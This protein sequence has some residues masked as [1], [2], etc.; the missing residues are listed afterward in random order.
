MTERFPP[1][2]DDVARFVQE[3]GLVGK[4]SPSKFY[5]YYHKQNFM[6]QGQPMDWRAKVCKWAATETRAVQMN[7]A[8]YDAISRTKK[9]EIT[10]EELWARVNSI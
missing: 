1:T 9:K 3:A 5:A 4:I 10:L 2:L 7:A 6:Y 8:D